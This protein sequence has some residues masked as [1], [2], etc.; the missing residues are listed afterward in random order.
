MIGKLQI[1]YLDTTRRVG[2]AEKKMVSEGLG[3]P[4]PRPVQSVIISSD[5]NMLKAGS[6]D[7]EEDTPNPWEV[8]G[9]L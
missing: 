2:D 7:D 3:M 6:E 1:G 8:N 5:K 9:S 4:I